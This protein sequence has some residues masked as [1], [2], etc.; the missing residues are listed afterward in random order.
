MAT[1]FRARSHKNCSW[2]PESAN[3]SSIG[4][5]KPSIS[6]RLNMI[7]FPIFF[8]FSHKGTKDV[9]FL[10][11]VCLRLGSHERFIRIC[12]E[13]VVASALVEHSQSQENF[14]RRRTQHTSLFEVLDG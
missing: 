4:G 8:L 14:R 3:S 12:R 6:E 2:I 7:R 1:C 9:L 10:R 5:P 11:C 13:F